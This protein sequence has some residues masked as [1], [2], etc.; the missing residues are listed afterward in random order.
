MWRNAKV[1]DDPQEAPRVPT[2]LIKVTSIATEVA[3]RHRM[4]P[5]HFCLFEHTVLHVGLR[6]R[7]RVLKCD[8][9]G[10]RGGCHVVYVFAADTRDGMPRNVAAPKV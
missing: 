7:W 6:A 3:W 5:I 2:P 10:Q 4:S 8:S 1:K 9:M